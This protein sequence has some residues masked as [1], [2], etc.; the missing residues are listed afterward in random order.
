MYIPYHVVLHG[1]LVSD[2]RRT[3]GMLWGVRTFSIASR[4]ARPGHSALDDQ[5]CQATENV[6]GLFSHPCV[7]Q[8]A[9]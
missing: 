5:A 1:T 6:R 4:V 9:P 8:G 7:I 2:D 3:A